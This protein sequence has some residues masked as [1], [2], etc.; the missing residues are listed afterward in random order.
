MG[1]RELTEIIA[2][3]GEAN[4]SFK[5]RFDVSEAELAKPNADLVFDGLDTFATV[6]LVSGTSCLVETIQSPI[7]FLASEWHRNLEV[8]PDT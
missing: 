7:P 6:Y 1:D 4:W 3:I 2:G 8:S 5:T